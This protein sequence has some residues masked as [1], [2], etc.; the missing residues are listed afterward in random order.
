MGVKAKLDRLQKAMR[1]N[2]A[3]FELRDGST[4]WYDEDEEW[5]VLFTHGTDCMRADHRGEPRP[6]PPE[7]LQA[8]AR[9]KNRRAAVAKLYPPHSYPF[10]AYDIEVLIERGVFE[11]RAFL[12]GSEYDE[13]YFARLVRGSGR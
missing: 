8:V 4:F 10:M 3:S 12:S 7:I 1:G 13:E 6:D 9:A 5:P 11:H 2:F